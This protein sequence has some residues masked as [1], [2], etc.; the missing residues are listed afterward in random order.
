MISSIQ[1]M[2]VIS[3]RYPATLRNYFD[4]SG[5]KCWVYS[6]WSFALMCHCRT[7]CQQTVNWIYFTLYNMNTCHQEPITGSWWHK[8]PNKPQSTRCKNYNY[9]WNSAWLSSCHA[10]CIQQVSWLVFLLMILNCI[11][12][13]QAAWNE[14]TCAA[15]SVY[16]WTVRFSIF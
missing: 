10:A 7:L 15:G 2:M 14:S 3:T 9:D 5:L 13:I 11:T 8:N 1:W 12:L 4:S 16:F 6:F